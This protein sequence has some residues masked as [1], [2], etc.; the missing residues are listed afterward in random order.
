MFVAANR[1]LH[2]QSR[3]ILSLV[4][5]QSQTIT[6]TPKCAF[7][8]APPSNEEAAKAREEWGQKY[9]DEC[10]AFEKEWKMIS[11]K[12]EKE[13][14]VYLEQE[15]GEMQRKKVDMLVD[16]MLDMNIFE[17]RY[18]A[19]SC[20]ERIQRTSGINPLKMNLDWPSVKQDDTGTWPPA[21]P[22]RF[23]Q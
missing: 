1:M 8:T 23:K 17:L 22:N 15:L 18:F 5:T 11:E 9:S 2:K 19:I 10:F 14:R 3:Q 20:K 16:K 12:I 13:Q 7:S 4:L 21:N 6:S